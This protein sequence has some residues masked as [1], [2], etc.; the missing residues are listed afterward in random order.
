MSGLEGDIQLIS[1]LRSGSIE[2]F[3]R[4]DAFCDLYDR[5]TRQIIGQVQEEKADGQL[6][7][8]GSFVASISELS[9]KWHWHRATVRN[10]VDGL[11]EMGYLAK[12]LIGKDYHFCMRIRAN[13]QVPLM[14][15][16][17]LL[18][19]ARHLLGHC[20]SLGYSDALIASF[21]G[22]YHEAVSTCCKG[23]DS[24]AGMARQD[25]VTILS[26]MGGMDH[27]ACSDTGIAE[28]IIRLVQTTFLPPYSWSWQKWTAAMKYLNHALAC[29]EFT[30]EPIPNLTPEKPVALIGFSHDETDLL[31]EVFDIMG[32]GF[33]VSPLNGGDEGRTVAG[34]SSSL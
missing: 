32:K 14:G 12:Q 26:L 10:F 13:M 11:A 19:M 17:C 25:A 24:K 16:E 23:R 15:K 27:S 4:F 7:Y 18:E 33:K 1:F 9:Q 3:S 22:A 2:R 20:D 6:G 21:L 8:S 29:G 31:K 28:E 30:G 5:M 34:S